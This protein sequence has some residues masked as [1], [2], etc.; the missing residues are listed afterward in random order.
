MYAA[1]INQGKQV[2]LTRLE[3][4]LDDPHWAVS[5]AASTALGPVYAALI[6]Q[7]KIEDSYLEA[8]RLW[9]EASLPFNE[10]IVSEYLEA[11]NPRAF[12]ANLRAQAEK[13]IR[14]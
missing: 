12:L 8:Y 13:A 4:K 11:S 1:L 3:S 9:N 2:S 14:E 6:H 10:A 5:L 7:G